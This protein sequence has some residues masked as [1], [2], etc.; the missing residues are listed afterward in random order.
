MAKKS[1]LT[2]VQ[3]TVNQLKT[4]EGM[5][6]YIVEHT[7]RWL[8][9]KPANESASDWVNPKTGK[10]DK[11]K[12]ESYWTSLHNYRNNL[13]KEAHDILKEG[14]GQEGYDLFRRVLVAYTPVCTSSNL[15]STDSQRYQTNWY[16]DLLE[17]KP[18]K[19]GST[20]ALKRENE[21]LASEIELLKAQMVEL[22]SAVKS[23]K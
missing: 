19:S 8:E 10:T 1:N 11:S 22:L 3:E 15:F 6:E 21:K 4:N 5:L 16:D 20:I 14:L 9:G 7:P 12:Q 18:V 23:G 2:K 17:Y 13:A